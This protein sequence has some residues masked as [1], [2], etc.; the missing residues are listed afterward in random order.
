MEGGAAFSDLRNRLTISVIDRGGREQK[1]RRHPKPGNALSKVTTSVFFLDHTTAMGE[2]K[3][4]EG[5]DTCAEQETVLLT[6]AIEI[7]AQ[8]MVGEVLL[9]QTGRQELDFQRGMSIDALQYIHQVDIRID[10]L[11]PTRR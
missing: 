8:G 11:Q 3:S 9:P 7:G 6:D 1:G 4:E 2:P 10:A 5:S